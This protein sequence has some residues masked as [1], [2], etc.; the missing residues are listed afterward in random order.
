MEE[1]ILR[2]KPKIW[3]TADLL[4]GS[5]IKQSDFPKYMMPFFALIMVESRLICELKD[6]LAEFGKKAISDF[7]EEEA[8]EDFIEELKEKDFGYNKYIVR[9]DKTLSSITQNDS[10][11]SIDFD[12]YLR[13]FDTKTQLLLGINRGSDEMRRIFR[14][15]RHSRRIG[16]EKDFVCYGQS[17]E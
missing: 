13:A 9:D 11:F 3:A 12:N 17:L 6:L 10:A 16:E 4:L 1:S 15:F 7:E 2:Y 5:G 8:L 14:Y